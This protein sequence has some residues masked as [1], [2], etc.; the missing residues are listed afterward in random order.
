MEN[1]SIELKSH[2]FCRYGRGFG[3]VESVLGENSIFNQPNGLYGLLFYTLITVLGKNYVSLR[4]TFEMLINFEFKSAISNSRMHSFPI[5]F[6]FFFISVLFSFI[7]LF[8]SLKTWKN[9]NKKKQDYRSVW[10]WPRSKCHWS[11]FPTFFQ[12]TWHICLCLCSAM[13]ALYASVFMQST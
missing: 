5:F 7:I 10:Y 13:H 8:L 2:N 3:L 1:F 12:C 4:L 6:F 11:Q 9:Q